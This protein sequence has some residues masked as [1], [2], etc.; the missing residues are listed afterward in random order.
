MKKIVIIIALVILLIY[1]LKGKDEP[2]V[3]VD[4]RLFNEVEIPSDEDLNKDPYYQFIKNIN[5]P[6]ISITCPNN[7]TSDR[8]GNCVCNSGFQ[9]APGKTGVLD[10][11]F[12][13]CQQ[14]DPLQQ[15]INVS[16]MDSNG[17][18]NCKAGYVKANNGQC[19]TPCISPSQTMNYNGSCSCAPGYINIGSGRDLNCQPNPCV[20]STLIPGGWNNNGICQ[21]NPGFQK[22][23]GRTEDRDPCYPICYSGSDMQSDGTCKSKPTI[24]VECPEGQYWNGSQCVL[25]TY[26]LG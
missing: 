6:C 4:M 9:K 14:T 16:E 17:N 22:A 12:P 21:C 7:S 15:G 1:V 11:C 26:S 5:F 2:Y 10:K 24:S 19:Y 13:I 18:C 23:P 20:N 8:F 3:D 25:A